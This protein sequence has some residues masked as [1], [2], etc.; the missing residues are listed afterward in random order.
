MR[1]RVQPITDLTV[2][3]TDPSARRPNPFRSSYDE[4]LTQ[5]GYELEQLGAEETIVEVSCRPGD[6]RRDGMLMARAKVD[7]PGVRISF[8]S[9]EHGAL[10]YATDTFEGRYYNDPPDW[11][12]NLRAIALGLEALRKVDRYGIVKRGE[13]YVGFKALPAGRAMPASHMTLTEAAELL[14]R[15]AIGDED[16]LRQRNVSRILAEP[17]VARQVWREAR[18]VAHPDR[19][20]GDHSVWDQVEQAAKVLGVGR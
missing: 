12:I 18:K 3:T 8:E 15:I 13:Q 2:F 7:H 14:E 16:E 6:V 20:D 10:T 5:L 1:Y 11:Q 9:D 19:R 17:L 4:T